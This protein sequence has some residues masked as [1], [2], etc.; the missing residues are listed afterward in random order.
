MH[1]FQQ[2]TDKRQ[3]KWRYETYLGDEGNKSQYLHKIWYNALTTSI[4][5][6]KP[7]TSIN[8][9]KYFN[10][11]IYVSYIQIHPVLTQF[12]SHSVYCQDNEHQAY[13]SEVGL[14]IFPP[15]IR[16]AKLLVRNRSSLLPITKAMASVKFDLPK[17]ENTNTSHYKNQ[18]FDPLHVLFWG[19]RKW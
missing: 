10:N 13:L 15:W 2:F 17:M 6:C 1:L 18:Q 5:T 16:L 14:L 8:L 12:H 3:A 7:H 9:R 11:K 4:T 19:G